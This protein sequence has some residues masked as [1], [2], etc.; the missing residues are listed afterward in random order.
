MAVYDLFCSVSSARVRLPLGAREPCAGRR[1]NKVPLA[2]HLLPEKQGAGF[3]TEIKTSLL[4]ES[5]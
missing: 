2:K 3:S 4:T 1:V 5:G